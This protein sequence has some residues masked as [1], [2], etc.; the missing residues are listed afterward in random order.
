MA[1]SGARQAT[2][3]ALL[4]A[5]AGCVESGRVSGHEP[6]R[7][8]RELPRPAPDEKASATDR[9]KA[10]E[11]SAAAGGAKVEKTDPGELRIG[12]ASTHVFHRADCPLLRG[13]PVAEQV[14]FTTRWDALDGGYRP[15]E[16]CKA[17]K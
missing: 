3:L 15:C 8:T 4:L 1:G 14:R 13:V 12:V 5:L 10:H 9:Y 17:V 16:D 11:E 2:R 7:V 6:D